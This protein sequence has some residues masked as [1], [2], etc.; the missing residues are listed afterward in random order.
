MGIVYVFD[1]L[2]VF[3][4]IDWENNFYVLQVIVEVVEAVGYDSHGDYIAYFISSFFGFYF[5]S[6]YSINMPHWLSITFFES[7]FE[8]IFIDFG[9]VRFFEGRIYIF[10][11][12]KH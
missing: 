4:K 2:I 7:S 12:K 8:A 10:Y 6:E 5:L 11:L 1:C 9:F 3:F